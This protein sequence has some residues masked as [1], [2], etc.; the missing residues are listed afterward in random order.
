MSVPRSTKLTLVIGVL[1]VLLA[2]GLRFFLVP[3]ASKLPDDLDVT[4]RY[5]GTGT[6]LNP[7]ALQS[8]DLANVVATNVPVAVNR[9]V[10]VSSVDGN[11]AITHDDLTVEAPGGVSMPSPHTYAID[12]TTM[13]SAPAPDRVDVE[14][15]TGL[16]VGWP[17]NPDQGASYSLYDFA[18]RTTAPMTFAGEGSV[19][20]RDVLN[21]TVDVAGPLA[22]PNILQAL[23]PAMPKAQL[24]SLA[25]LLPAD[26]QAKLG[27]AA[28]SLPDPVPF[29]YT[30]TSK[31]A[32]S[33]DRTLGTP[34]DGSLS[35]QVTANVVIGGENV[36]VMPVLALDTQLSDQSIANAASTASTVG[37][38][39]TLMGI[40]APIG[41][42]ALGVILIL[43]GLIRLRKHPSRTESTPHRD[44]EHSGAR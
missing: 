13:E 21:Y 34:A 22:D 31:L 10:Y 11:T 30:A 18:T 4:L 28:G 33:T 41:F 17:M 23:P 35:L 36:N 24:A 12:R 2:V 20:D 6:M 32:L 19:A 16:T 15:H 37:K 29:N 1:L 27:A 14:P 25:P 43:A 40:V 8:G 39:L 3:A 44:R 9:H 26:L 42:A 7:S 5:E 38:L